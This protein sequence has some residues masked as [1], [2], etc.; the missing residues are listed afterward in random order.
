MTNFA[1]LDWWLDFSENWIDTM[2]PNPEPDD[3]PETPLFPPLGED[4]DRDAENSDIETPVPVNQPDWQDEL[5]YYHSHLCGCPICAE[6]GQQ[7]QSRI[8]DFMRIASQW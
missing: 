4:G 1:M 2:T 8:K 6:A 3:I 5:K 7:R